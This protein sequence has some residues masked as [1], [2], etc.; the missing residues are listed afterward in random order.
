MKSIL[1]VTS[2]ILATISYCHSLVVH[3]DSP[4]LL[5]HARHKLRK[6]LMTR[7]SWP[8]F[9]SFEEDEALMRGARWVS[10]Y[11]GKRTVVLDDTDI[12]MT[13]PS[14]AGLNRRTYS[15]HYGG[16]YAKDTMAGTMR[17]VGFSCNFVDGS[18]EY[19]IFGLCQICII[20]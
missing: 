11:G 17:K 8:F 19:G 5:T 12:G 13:S 15:S 14:D 10:P 6:E 4:S 3:P 18:E 7:Q 1:G 20:L 9:A 16:N 2:N